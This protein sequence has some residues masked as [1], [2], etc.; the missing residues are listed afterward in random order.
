MAVLGG[1]HGS[2]S[3]A[4]E[5]PRVR[6][7]P[8]RLSMNRNL[9][10]GLALALATPAAARAQGQST[11][12]ASSVS[13]LSDAVKTL[14][15]GFAQLRSSLTAHNREAASR[16]EVRGMTDS[17]LLAFRRTSDTLSVLLVDRQRTAD[18][19]RHVVARWQDSA[20][21][22]AQKLATQNQDLAGQQ[23]QMAGLTDQVT[24]ERQRGDSL[25]SALSAVLGAQQT[26]LS[27]LFNKTQ[28]EL[29]VRQKRI[30]DLTDELLRAKE[31]PPPDTTQK[32]KKK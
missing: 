11:N 29:A 14:T 22:L 25:S 30:D 17:L 19:L 12:L 20:Q 13:A 31:P 18:S 7:M 28:T 2:P 24:R 15:E 5:Q 1:A 3:G 8:V 32:K 21:S 16:A 9:L 6:N 27:E 10:A 4:P 26:A 23:R